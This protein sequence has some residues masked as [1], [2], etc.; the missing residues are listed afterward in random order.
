MPWQRAVTA[1]EQLEAVVQFR[2]DLLRGEQLHARRRQ[3][4]RQRDAIQAAT[5]LAHR[6]CGPL[7]QYEVRRNHS[8]ALYEQ[9][10][11]FTGLDRV[12]PSAP[13]RSRHRQGPQ[14]VLPLSFHPQPLAAPPDHAQPCFHRTLHR[15]LHFRVLHVFDDPAPREDGKFR[16]LNSG[17]GGQSGPD[18]GE[19]KRPEPKEPAKPENAQAKK[20][21]EPPP[22]DEPPIGQKAPSPLKAHTVWSTPSARP[23]PN[24]E[25]RL[26]DASR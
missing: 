4:D 17:G 9:L 20:E 26:I 11:R 3:L 12:K 22:E 2:A 1:G 14:R 19:S 23:A 25:A 18:Q 7:V 6:L 5:D 15:L 8:R 16:R 24:S 21:P 10:Y 13:V